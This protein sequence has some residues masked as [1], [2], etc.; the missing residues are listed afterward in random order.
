AASITQR[1]VRSRS[2]T[3]S[4]RTTTQTLVI[5][6]SATTTTPQPA[7]PTTTQAL[8]VRGSLI[9]L[10]ALQTPPCVATRIRATR[11]STTPTWLTQPVLI[12][13]VTTISVSS[14]T[15]AVLPA[16]STPSAS[17]TTLFPY[18]VLPRKPSSAVSSVRTSLPCLLLCSLTRPAS[19]VP[20]PPRRGS[21]RTLNPWA[22]PAKR[23]FRL[24]Q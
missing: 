5:S 18:L 8:A 10:L 7:G 17:A 21:R 4:T 6:R 9:I 22:R 19:W 16:N 15:S 12:S 1:L 3:M 23:S 14:R 2:K 11:T 24:S 20:Y 13:P